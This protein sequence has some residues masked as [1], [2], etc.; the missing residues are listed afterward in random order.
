MIRTVEAPDGYFE[1]CRWLVESAKKHKSILDVG[2]ADGFMF[3][4]L[5][6]NVVEVDIKYMFPDKYRGKVKFL[7]ADAHNLP[8]KDKSF[9]CVILGEVLEHVSDPVRVLR[10]ARRV[11]RYI[12]ITTPNEYEWGIDQRPFTTATHIRFYTLEMLRNHIEESGARNYE[13]FKI[14]GGGWCFFAAE[15]RE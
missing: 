11:G 4:D 15:I 6:L 13:I 3:R 1:R 5:N 14:K 9:E 12:Y 10:E 7:L 2:C 8:L